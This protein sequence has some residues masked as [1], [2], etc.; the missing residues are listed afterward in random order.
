MKTPLEIILLIPFLRKGAK[1]NSGSDLLKF[2]RLFGDKRGTS[3]QIFF[4]YS[5]ARCYKKTGENERLNL[6]WVCNISFLG[7]LTSYLAKS[8]SR[9]REKIDALENL[10]LAF[11]RV[12]VNSHR[13]KTLADCF[14]FTNGIGNFT[15]MWSVS[16]STDV[17]R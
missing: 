12:Q 1:A 3:T 9:Q 2:T 10:F 14:H 17:L 16:S 6:T 8:Q 5:W 7:I 13:L 11:C 15:C 4:L